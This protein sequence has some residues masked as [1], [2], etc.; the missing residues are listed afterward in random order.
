MDVDVD[1]DAHSLCDDCCS[2]LTESLKR[3]TQAEN[4]ISRDFPPAAYLCLDFCSGVIKKR[5]KFFQQ[6][7]LEV[8]ELVEDD[9]FSQAFSYFNVQLFF[10]H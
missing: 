6:N 1:T 7:S 4:M 8:S 9:C 10:P 5:I 2:F 3:G